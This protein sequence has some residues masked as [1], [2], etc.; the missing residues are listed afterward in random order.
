MWPPPA[1]WAGRPLVTLQPPAPPMLPPPPTGIEFS[2]FAVGVV[3][4]AAAIVAC[5]ALCLQWLCCV[6]LLP[7]RRK[8]EQ[9]RDAQRQAIERVATAKRLVFER[10]EA[11]EQI[12]PAPRVRVVAWAGTD[13]ERATT[14]QRLPPPPL[15]ANPRL[16]RNKVAPAPKASAQ[17]EGPALPGE[18]WTTGHVLCCAFTIVQT[19]LGA[20][21]GAGIT[22]VLFGMLLIG[23]EQVALSNANV[24][25]ALTM[26]PLFV[27]IFSPMFAPMAMPEAAERG[28]LGY[29]GLTDLPFCMRC[30]PFLR[31]KY[32]I[33]RH[34]LLAVAVAS[35]WIPGGLFVLTQLLTPPYP[36]ATF[37]A[38]ASLYVLSI[39]LVIMPIGILAFCVQPNYERVMEVMSMHENKL[40]RLIERVIL[41]PTC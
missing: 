13:L 5:A 38:F 37:I 8:Q 41:V 7:V 40:F 27:T 6:A 2:F 28:W 21:L 34:G 19:A 30:L 36:R 20:C 29:V 16:P 23:Q 18:P 15:H 9:K 39:T 25:L 32:A 10:E 33:V 22:Y 17:T 11:L 1:N 26:S 12:A 4:A 31:A 24:V 35:L 14:A 3:I